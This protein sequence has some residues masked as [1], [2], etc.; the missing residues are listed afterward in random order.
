VAFHKQSQTQQ[1]PA[2]IV[3]AIRP[4]VFLWQAIRLPMFLLL[5]VL[6]PVVSFVLGSLALLGVLTAFFWR[7]VGPAHFPFLLVLSVS[8]SFE[9][10]LIPTPRRSRSSSTGRFWWPTIA[11]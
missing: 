11:N 5:S 7:F 10:V 4:R 9:L 8:L 2:N 3:N 6:E 1:T